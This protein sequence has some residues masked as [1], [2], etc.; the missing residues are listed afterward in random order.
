MFSSAPTLLDRLEGAPLF[1]EPPFLWDSLVKE[2]EWC[3]GEPSVTAEVMHQGHMAGQWGS[4]PCFPHLDPSGK[5]GRLD[6]GKAGRQNS[7]AAFREKPYLL[8][9]LQPGIKT[10]VLQQEA[11]AQGVELEIEVFIP[12]VGGDGMPHTGRGV[13]VNPAQLWANVVSVKN[14]D[15][16]CLLL[17]QMYS[18]LFGLRIAVMQFARWSMCLQ[19]MCRRVG[20]ILLSMHVDDAHFADGKSA[21]MKGQRLI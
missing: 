11:Q 14:P 3:F 1:E 18:V 17:V 16:R 20:G 6:N 15:T 21:D 5:S 13:P 2:N 10:R 9:P 19:M 12:Q 8:S 4:T 7:T